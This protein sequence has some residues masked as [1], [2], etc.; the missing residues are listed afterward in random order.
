[1]GAFMLRMLCVLLLLNACGGSK[2]VTDGFSSV[3]LTSSSVQ[4]RV[5]SLRDDYQEAIRFWTN[6]DNAC[7][8]PSQFFPASGC[9]VTPER[10]AVLR[11]GIEVTALNALNAAERARAAWEQNQNPATAAQ[12]D[13]AIKKARKE[14]DA[15]G[16]PK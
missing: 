9:T 8:H 11:T 15:L 16:I 3:A 4:Q 2:P 5:Q 7:N 13:T 10:L 1:M 12:L 6:Q 14:I